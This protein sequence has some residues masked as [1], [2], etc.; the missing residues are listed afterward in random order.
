VRNLALLVALFA[1]IQKGW[2]YGWTYYKERVAP[3]LICMSRSL[4]ALVY[5]YLGA[6][7]AGLLIA[8]VYLIAVRLG[9]SEGTEWRLGSSLIFAVKPGAPGLSGGPGML[10]V[11]L[12]VGL[13]AAVWVRIRCSIQIQRDAQAR[14]KAQDVKRKT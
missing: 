11:S 13:V 4:M 6:T 14:S 2:K 5:G 12:L 8:T 7:A 3:E 10:I 9:L 1:A